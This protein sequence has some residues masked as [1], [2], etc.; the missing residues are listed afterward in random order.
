MER[1]DVAQ[2]VLR[3]G[4]RVLV[5]RNEY[6]ARHREG[7]PAWG[8]PGGAREDGETLAEAAIRETREETGLTV[9][10]GRLLAL[11]EWLHLVHAVFAV[12]EAKVIGGEASP[13]PGEIAVELR[14][15]TPEE[16]DELMPWYPG[17]V[18]RLL[19][20]E[21]VYYADRT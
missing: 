18:R 11:G 4:D 10:T 17:G 15:V 1:V 13:Q 14:W 6:Q 7:V 19:G 8:F 5:V 12:F 3:E 9:E 21:V 20:P 2:A 16:A